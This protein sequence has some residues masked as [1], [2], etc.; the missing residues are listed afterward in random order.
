[1]PGS[2]GQGLVVRG[3]GVSVLCH[4]F[5]FERPASRAGFGCCVGVGVGVCACPVWM[6]WAAPGHLGVLQIR[7]RYIT[8]AITQEE[9][10]LQVPI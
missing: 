8:Y 5:V 4:L 1:M 7:P 3:V 9:G 6:F 2:C 10:N